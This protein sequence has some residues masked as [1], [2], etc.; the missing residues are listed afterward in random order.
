MTT[1]DVPMGMSPICVNKILF[2]LAFSTLNRILLRSIGAQ[3][4]AE[5]LR[6]ATSSLGKFQINLTFRSLI[7]T[8]A[9]EKELL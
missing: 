9:E 3:A 4:Q 2:N 8:F 6:Q 5:D 1:G 7:R